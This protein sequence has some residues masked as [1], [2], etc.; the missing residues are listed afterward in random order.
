MH[1]LPKGAS[2]IPKR[3]LSTHLP[4][5]NASRSFSVSSVRQLETQ[6]RPYDVVIVGGGPAGLGLAVAPDTR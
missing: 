6:S 1:R 2:F 5:S 4:T 3:S